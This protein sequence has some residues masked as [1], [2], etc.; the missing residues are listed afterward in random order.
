MTLQ[1]VKK[2]YYTIADH[3]ITIETPRIETTAKFITNFESFRNRGDFINGHPLVQ[4]LCNQLIPDPSISPTEKFNR[5][6]NHYTV[7]SFQETLIIEMTRQRKTHRL[8]ASKDWRTFYTDLSL[9]D[10]SEGPFLNNFT[11]IA[12][13]MTSSKL[14]TLKLHAS[15][16]EK[17]GKA[18]LFLGKS[19]TGKSTHSR[20]WQ[21]F[22][23][24]ST[25]LNDDE[26]VVRIFNDG[27]VKVYGSPWSGKTPC[28]K[29][30]SGKI[31]AI[32]HLFQSPENILTR[33][34]G[35]SALSSVFQS[36]SVLRSNKQ[37]K[38]LVFDSVADLIETVPV[39]RLDCR[40][41][42]EAVSLTET[43]LPE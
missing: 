31:M 30:I 4:L 22:V 19:G 28:Y 29:N 1:H 40:P 10:E 25:L 33:L 39:Y 41:D 7:Y 11:M 13:T 35:I 9:T 17:K 6:L 43:L 20:L 21:E 26:P 27:N 15:V 8:M 5:D 3:L 34:E 16:I 32:V 23:P 14:K 38:D 36:C 42:R 37:N 2:L 12:Y 24:G 18:V